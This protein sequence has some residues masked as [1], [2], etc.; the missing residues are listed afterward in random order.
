MGWFC[1]KRGYSSTFRQA[2]PFVGILA[3]AATRNRLYRDTAPWPIGGNRV[4]GALKSL[5][6]ALR[7]FCRRGAV[8]TLGPADRIQRVF[9]TQQQESAREGGRRR[10]RCLQVILCLELELFSNRHHAD[11]TVH[12]GQVQVAVGQYR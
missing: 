10:D 6:G 3:L 1:A 12:G 4:Q 7:C 8:A 11:H 5:R 9:T 2:K